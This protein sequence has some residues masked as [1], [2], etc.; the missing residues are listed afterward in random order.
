MPDHDHP[1]CET[2]I[3]D[4]SQMNVFRSRTELLEILSRYKDNLRWY[5]E[6]RNRLVAENQSLRAE[7]GLERMKTH[8]QRD[9]PE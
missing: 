7:I 6:E 8:H 3:A 9:Y 2:L 5:V 4:E 1:P